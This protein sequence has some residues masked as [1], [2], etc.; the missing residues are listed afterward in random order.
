M[1]PPSPAPR[2]FSLFCRCT[3]SVVP[4]LSRI[5]W[6]SSHPQCVFS[7]R[8]L[9]ED[10]DYQGSNDGHSFGLLWKDLGPPEADD[11]SRWSGVSTTANRESPWPEIFIR[12]SA[13]PEERP[14]VKPY[15]S[16][17]WRWGRGL[18]LESHEKV[19]FECVGWR[20]KVPGSDFGLTYRT[21]LLLYLE[22]N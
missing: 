22:T 11:P 9:S 12:S 19:K 13:R 8:S 21:Q 5:V 10:C 20:F 7:W 18:T 16:R 17:S 1:H 6:P 14:L 2:L 4:S 3:P 15:R